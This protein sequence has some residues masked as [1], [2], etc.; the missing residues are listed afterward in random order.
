MEINNVAF[1]YAEVVNAR[2]NIVRDRIIEAAIC[3]YTSVSIDVRLMSD[4]TIKNLEEK[5]Y[6]VKPH[7]TSEYAVT[8]Y[9]VYFGKEE[10][11]NFS[12]K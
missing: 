6:R 9:V 8:Y 4:E 11:E 12:V 5:G 7:F 2:Q 1:M 3:G 10:A